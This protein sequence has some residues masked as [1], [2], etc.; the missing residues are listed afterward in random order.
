MADKRLIIAI[1]SLSGDWSAKHQ[2]HHT[3][4]H[5]QITTCPFVI[6]SPC[7]RII[8]HLSVYQHNCYL[9]SIAF[10]INLT[11]YNILSVT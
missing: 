11:H 4:K 8:L 2:A 1:V 3:H 6:L 5:C 10:V 9:F 7:I